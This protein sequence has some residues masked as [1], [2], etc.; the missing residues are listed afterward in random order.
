MNRVEDRFW[1]PREANLLVA[2]KKSKPCASVPQKMACDHSVEYKEL[3]SRKA[4]N[5]H[6][7]ARFAIQK[8]TD[9]PYHLQSLGESAGTG[10]S[11]LRSFCSSG[12]VR[13]SLEI[14]TW[15]AGPGTV[16]RVSPL[17][18]A[19]GNHELFIPRV[20]FLNWLMSRSWSC[21]FLA[22]A[23]RTNAGAES[24]LNFSRIARRPVAERSI[25]CSGMSRVR[26][27]FQTVSGNL[28]RRSA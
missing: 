27:K 12:A 2:G 5:L 3:T 15:V 16:R 1:P 8:P 13:R 20:R 17:P 9:R 4:E 18:S 21:A 19:Q 7:G 25:F 28:A 6:R 24:C 14:R 26:E 11:Q 22:F 23:S 10:L